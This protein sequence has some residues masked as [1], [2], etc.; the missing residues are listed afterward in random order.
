MKN[1]TTV[2]IACFAVV[3]SCLGQ[4]QK[5]EYATVYMKMFYQGNTIIYDQSG[6]SQSPVLRMPD[7]SVGIIHD[8]RTENF[9]AERPSKEA[10]ILSIAHMLHYMAS[11]GWILKTSNVLPYEGD[12]GN[13][14]SS[15]IINTNEYIQL[16]IF[17]RPYK[18]D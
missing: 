15:S 4:D 18:T 3:S 10:R 8:S 7:G 2:I 12:S 1:L 11:F 17:E 16:L 9:N 14:S 5:V 6:A 13:N